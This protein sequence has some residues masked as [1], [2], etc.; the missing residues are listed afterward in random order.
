MVSG[1][2]TKKRGED[3]REDDEVNKTVR[4]KRQGRG[5]RL[6]CPTLSSAGECVRRKQ[7]AWMKE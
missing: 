1:G 7:C 5:G 2:G 6:W 3:R 4:Q